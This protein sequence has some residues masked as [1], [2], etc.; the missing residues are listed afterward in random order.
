MVFKFLVPLGAALVLAGASHAQTA[1]SALSL[2]ARAYDTVIS[3]DQR[4]WRPAGVVEY[5]HTPGQ[6]M[7]DLRAVFAGPWSESLSRLSVNSR[8]VRVVLPDGTEVEPSASYR[9]A[10]QMALSPQS[11]SASRPRDFPTSPGNIFWNSTFRV[12]AGT[13]TIELRITGDE[14]S[15][16]AE[17]AVPPPG[18]EVDP[19][20]FASFRPGT[21][22]RFREVH[23]EEGRDTRLLQSMM[24]APAGH[25]F[26]EI[27]IE[28]SATGSN[29][30]DGGQRFNWHTHNFRLVG[31]D[32]T[33]MPLIG[34][35]FMRQL[36][37]S[38]FNGVDVGRSAQRTVLW[39]V[40]EGVT[41]LTLR[42]AETPV[43]AVS[44]AS[45]TILDSVR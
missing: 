30:M 39:L 44:L 3:W 13:Q 12:P 18:H 19:A 8:D 27:E 25:V 5:V 6:I 42:F 43:A 35:R 26:A 28:V 41:D 38:Q 21:V 29:Q 11:L 7:L 17:V 10:G 22:R 37:D 4:D 15:F 24:R 31:P 34:E 32:G 16:S 40:P 45:A 14:A 23:L 9:Y 1:L 20:S 2:E 33:T 36:L